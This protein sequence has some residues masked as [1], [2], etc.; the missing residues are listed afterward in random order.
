MADFD[1]V[2]R[3]GR[4]FA[5]NALIQ[6]DIACGGGAIAAIGK[7][8][9][10]GRQ[11]LDATGKLVLPGGIDAHCHIDQLT[12]TGARTADTFRSASVSAAFGGTTTLMPF[13]VQHRGMSL[14][15][16]VE[17]Y[18]ARA[19]GQSVVDYAFHLIVTDTTPQTLE[20]D[21][22]AL[23]A[24][25]FTSVK[26]YL[27]YDALKLDDR[28]ALDV[29]A[30]ARR[31]QMM[32]M[33]HAESHDLIAWL[34]E[35]ML[36]HG[37]SDLKYLS[38]SRPIIAERDAT[39]H[40][41]TMAELID[42]PILIVHV[43][44]RYTLEQIRWSRTEGVRTYAETCPQYLVLS[45]KDLD[46]PDFEAA[47]YCCSPPLRD[48]RH[49]KALWEGLADGSIDVY[50]SDHSAF[51][52]EGTEGKMRNGRQAAFNKVPYGLPGLE[53]R[54]PLLFSEGVVK[55]R[56]SLENFVRVTASRPAELYGL[57]GRKGVLAPGAD[58]DIVIWDEKKRVQIGTDILHDGLDYTPYEGMEVEG[59]PETTI[60][61]GEIV[62][63]RGELR[64]QE[65]SGQLL[66]CAR[67]RASLPTMRPVTGFDVTD[68]TLT[69]G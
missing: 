51:F 8:L 66:A 64:A 48:R 52:F 9:P 17:D 55:G 5:G 23:A 39:H 63:H 43:S 54:M 62:C 58:A 60:I 13:A 50:S 22:P 25:G 38:R 46:R 14:R 42:V 1:L 44:S 45:E 4:I 34:T 53:T 21:I 56:L 3:N 65:A 69:F 68:N 40:A 30:V 47:K 24:E 27:T 33:I 16:A 36:A 61:R 49:Q 41:I 26:I 20:T 35:R 12:S 28:S 32:V 67:P 59:W 10:A 11:E 18:K 19:A 29:M 6:G 31:E 7:D 15:A 2:I 37:Y 57:E